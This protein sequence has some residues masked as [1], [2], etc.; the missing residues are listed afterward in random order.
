MQ[1]GCLSAL[2]LVAAIAGA[3]QSSSSVQSPATQEQKHAWLVEDSA[4]TA[5][6][7]G[8]D[9]VDGQVAWASGSHGTVL[10]TTDG[11]AHWQKCAV[12]DAATDGDTLDFR[13]V[14]AWD[15]ATAIVMASGAG[16]KSRLYKTV[17]G[18]ITWTLLYKNPDSP[19]GFFDSFWLNALYGEGILLGDPVKGRFTVF[20]TDDG[21][22]NW[23]RDGGKSLALDGNS[24]AAFAASNSSIARGAGKYLDGFVTGGKSGAVLYKSWTAPHFGKLPELHLRRGESA[25]PDWTL[26][27]LPLAG[28]SE[29]TGAFSIGYRVLESSPT[30]MFRKGETTGYSSVWRFVVVGGDYTKPNVSKGTA[31]W[32]EDDGRH[33]RA[34]AVPPHGYRSSVEW[35]A[36]GKVWVTAGSN[37]SDVSRDEGRTWQKLDDGNWNALSLPFIVGEKGRIGKLDATAI[38]SAQ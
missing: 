17:D 25:D 8:I 29:A 18:C 35:S 7:R 30:G 2:L 28:G 16:E 6:L 32:S 10:K 14:E 33:W 31:A 22:Q 27:G 9:S 20:R 24:L 38:P 4:T 23:K 12:P 1:S 3:G 34:A 11:G 13:G 21:G 5:S 19:D 15:S 37:G 36:D 26:S